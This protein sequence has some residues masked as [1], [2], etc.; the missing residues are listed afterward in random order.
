M[1]LKAK[2]QH[3]LS[4]H[5]GGLNTKNCILALIYPGNQDISS[6]HRDR[7]DRDEVTI[8]ADAY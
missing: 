7:E 5:A 1:F 2:S 4:M 3:T 6:A 8:E